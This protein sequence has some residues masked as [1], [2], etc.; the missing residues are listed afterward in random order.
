MSTAQEPQKPN[1]QKSKDGAPVGPPVSVPDQD[2]E[3]LLRVGM[4]VILATGPMGDTC[5]ILPGRI[6]G[7]SQGRFILMELD[8]MTYHSRVFNTSRSTLLRFLV[9]GRA[10]GLRVRI[11][12]SRLTQQDL[13]LK[14][15]WPHEAHCSVV[16]SEHR[17]QLDVPCSVT[18]PG[19]LMVPGKL[20]NI[21]RSGCGLYV[22]VATSAGA[23]LSCSFQLPNGFSLSSVICDVR[24]AEADGEGSIVGCVFTNLDTSLAKTLEFMVESRLLLSGKTDVKMPQV[25]IL[26]RPD[27]AVDTLLGRLTEKNVCGRVVYDLLHAF[28]WLGSTRAAAFF[29][30]AQIDAMPVKDF[31]RI[32]RKSTE[33]K[34]LPIYVVGK[35]V[36]P[37]AFPEA[38]GTFPALDDVDKIV[39]IVM[40]DRPPDEA[41]R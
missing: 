33:C 41:P 6:L 19:G 40:R 12:S 7:W 4:P 10:C 9:D 26:T 5:G 17:V 36:D 38:T 2:I 18:M 28:A 23:S 27:R 13:G 16:R 39:E 30:D 20:R 31:C 32:L 35:D 21:S 24:H 14:L 37:A 11:L 25:L 15:G 34:N 3:K 1:V 22:P 29:I 8:T